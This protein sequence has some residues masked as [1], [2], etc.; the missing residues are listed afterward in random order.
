[1]SVNRIIARRYHL[2]AHSK[3][4]E[5][6]QQYIKYDEIDRIIKRSKRLSKHLF[7]YF[8]GFNISDLF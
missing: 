7:L 8:T 5:V 4:K 6:K 2:Q 3:I 1:M